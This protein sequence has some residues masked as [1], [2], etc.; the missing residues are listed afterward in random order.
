MSPVHLRKLG[1][2]RNQPD[3]RESFSRTRIPG[4][5]HLGHRGGWQEIE[6]DH[7][8]SSIHFPIQ[9]KPQTRG[10]EGYGSI[11][12][13]PPTPQG[14]IPMENVQKKVKPSIPLGRTWGKLPE[15]MSQR[16]RL[17]RAYGN[18]H[19]LES[20]QTSQTSGGEANQDK[21]ESSHYPAIEEQLNQTG[22]TQIPSGSQ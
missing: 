1:I 11:S 19:R 14:P 9:T 20:H 6:G 12:S 3:D 13:A 21:G 7:T 16:D 8:H 17:Q 15:D 5:G 22:H 18:H 10:M 4:R 2:Q